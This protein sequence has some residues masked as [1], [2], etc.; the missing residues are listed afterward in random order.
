MLLLFSHVGKRLRAGNYA[1]M[2]LYLPRDPK[3]RKS[4]INKHQKSLLLQLFMRQRCY[5][6]GWWGRSVQKQGQWRPLVV[7]TATAGVLFVPALLS[8]SHLFMQERVLLSMFRNR[9]SFYRTLFLIFLYCILTAKIEQL[10]FPCC[11]IDN[12]AD[13]WCFW[14][15]S[16]FL[17]REKLLKSGA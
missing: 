4:K 14:F 13:Y 1:E 12:H 2:K 9:I 17:Q 10:L 7:A 16:N 3:L 8:V 11:V 5:L 6:V 15:H